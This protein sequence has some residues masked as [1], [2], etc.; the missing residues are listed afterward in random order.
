[1]NK[2]QFLA[3]FIS[4]VFYT[5]A[6]RLSRDLHEGIAYSTTDSYLQALM[7]QQNTFQK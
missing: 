1:M 4:L 7:D 6:I 5:S 2:I 3:L